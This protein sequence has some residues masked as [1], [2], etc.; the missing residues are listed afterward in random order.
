MGCEIN[1]LF[2]GK[3]VQDMQTMQLIPYGMSAVILVLW[4]ISGMSFSDSKVITV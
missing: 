2:P 3:V 4:S 1:H